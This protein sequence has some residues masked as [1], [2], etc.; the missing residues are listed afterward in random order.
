MAIHHALRRGKRQPVQGILLDV[1][2]TLFSLAN[3]R[4]PFERCGI[5]PELVSLWFASILRDGFALAAAGDYQRLADIATSN[6]IAHDA[7]RLGAAEAHMVLECLRSLEPHPD[8]A[9]GLQLIRDAGV[10]VMTLT[11]GDAALSEALFASAGLCHLVDGFLSADTVR[12]W[13]PAPEPYAYGVAQIGWPAANVALIAAHDWDVHGAWRAGLQT[14]YIARC[15]NAPS[16]VF[17]A[18]DVSGGDLPSV[19]EKLLLGQ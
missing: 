15:R 7:Q 16:S 12:R 11:V 19:V 8:V 6:F 17:H 2:Q 14:G 13:K 1:H 5:N 18:A 10:R 3:L 4:A 9:R